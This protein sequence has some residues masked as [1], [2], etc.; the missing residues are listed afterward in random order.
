MT[1]NWMKKTVIATTCCFALL[2]GASVIDGINVGQAHAA[3]ATT[4][5]AKADSI[6]AYAKSLQGKVTYKFGTNNTSKLIFD[7]SSFTKYVFGKYGVSLKW[8]TS[9]QRLQ[10]TYVAKSNLKKGDLIF[11][12]N[13]KTSTIN[14]V[15]IYIGNGQFIHNT[16]GTNMNGVYIRNLSDYSSRY[17]TARRVL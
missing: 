4:A 14:H 11:F 12:N 5:S 16:I 2:S 8:G 17:A 7:C 13:G 3:A 6:I 1:L 15:G 9:S 10:G